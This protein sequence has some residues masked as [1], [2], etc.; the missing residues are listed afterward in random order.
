MSMIGAQGQNYTNSVANPAYASFNQPSIYP[1]ITPKTEVVD[2]TLPVNT[3]QTEIPVKEDNLDPKQIEELIQ[4]VINK[5]T[6]ALDDSLQM[7]SEGLDQDNN[8]AMHQSVSSSGQTIDGCQETKPDMVGIAVS[9]MKGESSPT[10]SPNTSPSLPTSFATEPKHALLNMG[11]Q[12]SAAQPS[13]SVQSPLAASTPFKPHLISAPEECEDQPSTEYKSG[14]FGD[15]DI[16]DKLET[17]NDK[18]DS[19]YVDNETSNRDHLMGHSIQK[20]QDERPKGR[21]PGDRNFM[22]APMSPDQ[23]SNDSAMNNSNHSNHSGSGGEES[24]RESEAT[25]IDGIYYCHLCNYSGTSK[26]HFNAH[27]N[28]HFEHQCPNC[29]Y[30]SRTEGRLNRHIKDFHSQNP[31]ENYSG[32][33]VARNNPNIQG[34]PKVYRCKQCEFVSQTKVEFWEHSRGHIKDDKILQCPKCPFVTEYKHH[35]EYHLRNHFGSKPFKC[36]KCN[37]SCVNK[38]MLNSHM[39]SHTNVYQYRC[40]DCTYATK[41]CHSLKLHL[42]K[43]SHKPA[44]ILNMDGSMDADSGIEFPPRRGPPRGPRGPRKEKPAN[45]NN[46]PLMLNPA[47]MALQGFGG[48]RPNFI[49]PMNPY[50]PMMPQMANGGFPAMHPPAMIPPNMATSPSSVPFS[51]AAPPPKEQPS[52]NQQSPSPRIKQEPGILKCNLCEFASDNHKMFSQHILEVHAAENQDLFSM[53]GIN[54]EALVD[55]HRDVAQ[56]M[57]TS[58]QGIMALPRGMIISPQKIGNT[59]PVKDSNHQLH[60]HTENVGANNRPSPRSWP[61]DQPNPN[62]LRHDKPRSSN[63]LPDLDR[64]ES[65]SSDLVIDLSRPNSRES[66]TSSSNQSA[67]DHDVKRESPLDLTRAEPGHAMKRSIDMVGISQ[68]S[69]ADISSGR[70]RSRKGKAYRLDKLCLR[71]QEGGTDDEVNSDYSPEIMEPVE[72]SPVSLEGGIIR[73]QKQEMDS[74]RKNNE[75]YSSKHIQGHSYM[76]NSIDR[77]AGPKMAA[78]RHHIPSDAE[79]AVKAAYHQSLQI[80]AQKFIRDPQAQFSP[81]IPLSNGY[82]TQGEEAPQHP[83]IDPQLIAHMR[84]QMAAQIEEARSGKSYECRHCDI[85]FRDCIMYTMHMGYHGYQNPF[86]CNMCGHESTDK[87]DFFLHIARASHA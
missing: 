76:R 29:D 32:T 5:R 18:Y 60:V 11:H 19:S 39:K 23:M 31:P 50:W 82:V 55:D 21:P 37:Y 57:M 83:A 44:T 78:T 75:E 54:S 4:D 53:F 22:Y 17:I 49:N 30:A 27:M 6:R 43:Y 80:R 40:A 13:A 25:S 68:P 73:K 14:Q 46:M 71:L 20:S 65:Q 87:V 67:A 52:P 66:E 48:P 10:E 56:K 58:P 38:S 63:S 36:T 59:S 72:T 69:Q 70:K 79:K 2:R 84:Q 85:A 24:Y 41:Y 45:N 81:G 42:R 1:N 47:L 16:P 28:S 26:F 34:R 35:L 15:N 12:L 9:S 8:R 77:E 64:M 86:K 51:T 3:S 7:Q 33:R 74:Y 62:G 61:N